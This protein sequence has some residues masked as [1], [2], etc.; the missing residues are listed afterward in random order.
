M[1]LGSI[2]NAYE[3]YKQHDFSLS[4]Q[5]RLIAILG[6]PEYVSREINERPSG[7]GGALYI[8]SASIPGRSVQNI[9]VPYQG[10][11]FNK[12]G[13]VKYE[14]NPWSVTFKTPGTYLVRNALEAWSFEMFSDETSC[15]NFRIPCNSAIIRLGLTDSNCNIIRVYDLIGV[16]PS[17]LG[18]ISYNIENNELTEFEVSFYY[19]YWRL[20]PNFDTGKVD[21]TLAQQALIAST[22]AGYHS[23]ILQKE[24]EC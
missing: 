12:P 6:A 11:T 4:H 8:R 10:F 19:Q 24:A 18:A 3:V 14:D 1:S 15:G 22:Y 16:Y 13:A 20:V 9:E 7:E 5:F 17:K 21:S 23:T 2:R